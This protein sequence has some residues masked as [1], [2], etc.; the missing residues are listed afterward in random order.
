M[1]ETRAEYTTDS[2]HDEV[3]DKSHDHSYFSMMPNCLDDWLDPYQ[4][5]LYAHYKRVCGET[6]LC[7]QS[8]KTTAEKCKMSVGKVSETKQELCAMGLIDIKQKERPNGGLPYHEITI[9]DIW[10]RNIL[11][12]S[13]SSQDERPSSYS[14]LAS[15]PGELKKTPLK[16]DPTEEEKEQESATADTTPRS[17]EDWLAAGQE[18]ANKNAVLRQMYTV[19]FSDRESPDYGYIG[20]VAK[21]VGGPGRLAQLLWQAASQRPTGDVLAYIQATVKGK[22]NGNGASTP[23]IVDQNAPETN[24]TEPVEVPEHYEQ[25]QA[26]LSHLRAERGK[27]AVDQWLRRSRLLCYNVDG[28]TV[29]LADDACLEWVDT[30]AADIGDILNTPVSFVVTEAETPAWAIGS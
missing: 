12:C 21:R 20:T 16:E 6:G 3:N 15:S 10:Q 24:V 1:T 13:P 4:Y 30:W 7:W 9:V 2:S 27:P 23:R 18:S 29:E 26:V 22:R 14:E 5:R 25:W 8:T 28:A 19:L 17:F 11:Y